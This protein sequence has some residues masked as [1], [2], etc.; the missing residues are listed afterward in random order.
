MASKVRPIALASRCSE[1]GSQTTMPRTSLQERSQARAT[2][3][4][5]PPLRAVSKARLTTKGY[6]AVAGCTGNSP[7]RKLAAPSAA[8]TS[9]ST[10][11]SLMRNACRNAPVCAGVNSPRRRL[12]KASRASS[13]V[14]SLDNVLPRPTF[15]RKARILSGSCICVFKLQEIESTMQSASGASPPLH[16]LPNSNPIDPRCDWHA[17]CNKEEALAQLQF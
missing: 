9:S 14:R 5:T 6:S 1:G 2:S 3:D 4:T 13:R 15:F 12:A 16:S 11:V 7:C 17:L 10:E 8:P